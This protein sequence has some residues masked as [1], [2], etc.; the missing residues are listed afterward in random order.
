[1]KKVTIT[2]RRSLSEV[3]CSSVEDGRGKKEGGIGNLG[4]VKIAKMIHQRLESSTFNKK[5][6]QKRK[7]SNGKLTYLE[8][9]SENLRHQL[10]H[11]L[12][13]SKKAKNEMVGVDLNF[14]VRISFMPSRFRR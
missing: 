13:A 7:S 5:N 8:L 2:L 6:G 9:A 3:S 12:L 10:G 11:Y 4:S 14:S 1:M